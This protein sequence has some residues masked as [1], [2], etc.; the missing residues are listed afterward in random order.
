MMYQAIVNS[1]VKIFNEDAYLNKVISSELEKNKFSD[2]EKRLYTK[3]TYGVVE[4]KI[5]LDYYLQPFIKGVRVKPFIKNVLRI[6]TYVI[7]DMDMANHYIVSTLVDLVKKVDLRSTKFVNGVLRNFERTPRRTYDNLPK[8]EY[9]SI[10][11]SMPLELV[12]II[13]KDYGIKKAEEILEAYIDSNNINSYRINP[14]L[15]ENAEELKKELI[16]KDE[17]IIIEDDMIYT[18]KSL[19]NTQYFKNG[20]IIAQDYSSSLP[21]RKLNPVEND[22]ILDT[23]SAPGMKTIQM[24]GMM[25]NSG[26]II[27]MDIYE[28]KLNLIKENANKYHATNIKTLLEDATKVKFDI[29]FDKILVDTPCSG[30]GVIGHKPD[31]KYHMTSN[32]INEL[33][34]I[35]YDILSNVSKYLKVG[36]VLVFSTCTITKKENEDLITKFLKNNLNFIKLEEEKILPSKDKVQDGFYICKLKKEEEN[37]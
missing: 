37:D 35:S 9:L 23:C 4:N 33:A 26:K 30:L 20:H 29:K 16:T 18:K 11:Y 34:T 22:V 10:K 12:N 17:N 1:L 27:A 3:I 31:L 6:G 5:R 14:L 2:L 28:H 24:A 36:G 32:K 8:K 13:I 21:P 15:V 25:K 7:N 19:I